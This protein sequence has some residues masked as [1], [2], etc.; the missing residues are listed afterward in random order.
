MTA[1][2]SF[3]TDLRR[4]VEP[5]E[6]EMGD[7]WWQANVSASEESD[8][9]AA[10]AQKAI[11]RLYADKAMFDSLRGMDAAGFSADDARQHSLLLYTVAANQMDDAT[12]EELVD[13]ERRVESAYNTHRPLLRGEPTGENALRDILR[14]S[15]DNELRREAWEVSKEIGTVVEKD[16]LRLVEIRNREARRL[17]YPDF[18]QMS[19]KLQEQDVDS[20]FAL[21]DSVTAQ[22]DDL[23]KKYKAQLDAKLAARFGVAVNEL[24]PYHYPDPFFQEAPS[25]DAD[26]DDFYKGKNLETLT[27]AFFDAIS[28]DVRDILERSDLYEREKKV[29]ARLLYQRRSLRRCARFV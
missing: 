9:R 19:L 14:V 11:T 24:Q 20:L 28:L 8:E 15:E 5:L 7:A 3:L 27:V 22:T 25:G 16:V 17:G 13:T 23:W 21:L 6:I 2:S 10:A 4:R 12:I 18:Y 1:I 26:F 29:S